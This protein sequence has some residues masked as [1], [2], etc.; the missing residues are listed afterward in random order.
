MKI[1]DLRKYFKTDL[2][3]AESLGVT[4]RYIKGLLKKEYEVKA[5]SPLDKLIDQFLHIKKTF[6][7]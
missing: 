2:E 5:G 4:D 3:L 6:S 7:N 1:H